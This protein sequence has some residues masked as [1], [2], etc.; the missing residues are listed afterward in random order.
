MRKHIT[1]LV[2]FALVFA[3]SAAAGTRREDDMRRME[4]A[5]EVLRA[6]ERAPDKAIP[7][8]IMHSAKCIAVIPGEKKWRFS[9]AGTGAKAW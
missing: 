2:I 9:W 4:N 7:D 5:A 6:I 8:K 3:A 1:T